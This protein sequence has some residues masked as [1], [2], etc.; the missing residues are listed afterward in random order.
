MYMQKHS[1]AF[2]QDSKRLVQAGY[3]FNFNVCLPAT[4]PASLT[5]WLFHSHAG[6]RAN[7]ICR[8]PRRR[9]QNNSAH[10]QILVYEKKYLN[11]LLKSLK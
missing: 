5:A 4:V 11:Q 8:E 2:T 3:T 1:P 10:D 6:T 9:M 7:F